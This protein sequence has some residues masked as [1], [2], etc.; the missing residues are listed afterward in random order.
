M[1]GGQLRP[2]LEKLS[3]ISC[4]LA[5][6]RQQKFSCK[7]I[8]RSQLT[9]WRLGVQPGFLFGEARF[10]MRT[11]LVKATVWGAMGGAIGLAV[12]GFGWVG[13][14]T[15]TSADL[16]A[17]IRSE[18]AVVSALAPIC[19]NQFRQVPDAAAQQAALAAKSSWERRQLV[20]ASPWA[21]MPGST[22]VADDVANACVG[23]ILSLKL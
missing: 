10:E 22:E 16:I 3:A 9:T 5:A 2:Q 21:R 19:A 13:W 6:K 8:P 4:L 23:L 18:A 14:K 15:S 11:D 1:S 17:K 7:L 12:V 20:E